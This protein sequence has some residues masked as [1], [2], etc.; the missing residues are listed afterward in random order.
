M[1]DNLTVALDRAADRRQRLTLQ[2]FESSA[3]AD[4]HD[5]QFWMQIP[6]NERLLQVW[7]LSLEQWELAGNPPHEPRL[8]RSV[9]RVRRR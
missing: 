2:R 7:R 5:L 4:G 1:G 3:E 6:E 8:H 9:A